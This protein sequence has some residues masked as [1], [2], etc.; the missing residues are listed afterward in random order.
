MCGKNMWWWIFPCACNVRFVFPQLLGFDFFIRRAAISISISIDCLPDPISVQQWPNSLHTVGL[1][2]CS[3]ATEFHSVQNPKIDS[4]TSSDQ[5][6]PSNAGS[7]C[8]VPPL[9]HPLLQLWGNPL[10]ML[11]RCVLVWGVRALAVTTP[12]LILT[13][14]TSLRLT[15]WLASEVSSWIFP[16]GYS[17]FLL[18]DEFLLSDVLTLLS[19][20]V[21][22]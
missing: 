11:R 7:P 16:T 21:L 20:R 15:I 4:D 9:L 22:L 12:L 10:G 6:E 8:L 19:V 14:T 2:C 13:T 1:S 3:T 18:I 17:T 5:Y